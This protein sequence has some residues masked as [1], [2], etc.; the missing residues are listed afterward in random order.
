MLR[1]GAVANR[2]LGKVDL[3]AG[4]I[5]V[6]LSPR[7]SIWRRSHLTCRPNQMIQI[8]MPAI[9]T[10]QEA[11]MRMS[12]AGMLRKKA[13]AER[14]AQRGGEGRDHQTTAPSPPTMS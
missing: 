13:L 2:L 5:D 1:A 9:T 11:R 7:A 12:C 8:V 10:P 3:F 4:P 14:C 6:T